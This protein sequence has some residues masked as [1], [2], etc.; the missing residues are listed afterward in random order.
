MR[1]RF[2]ALALVGRRTEAG[3]GEGEAGG[4]QR[5]RQIHG[6][7]PNAADGVDGHQ[8]V[9][10]TVQ[11]DGGAVMGTEDR[12]RRGNHALTRSLLAVAVPL[13]SQSARSRS[14]ARQPIC[15][16]QPSSVVSRDVSATK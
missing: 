16:F 11:R 1:L 14:P 3:E 2:G 8:H 9:A 15:A 6:I 12:L 7:A 5:C 10:R 13:R 4:L